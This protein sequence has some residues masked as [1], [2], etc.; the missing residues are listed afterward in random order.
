VWLARRR[1]QIECAARVARAHQGA[2]AS[3]PRYHPLA[4]RLPLASRTV[5]ALIA[6]NP[7]Y[8][9]PLV[10]GGDGSTDIDVLVETYFQR[11]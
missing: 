11:G 7:R 6:Q 3:P 10:N 1:G 8:I 4:A 2:G 9:R 5:G